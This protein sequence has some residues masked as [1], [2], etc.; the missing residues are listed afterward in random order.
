MY[1]VSTVVL[2]RWA[3]DADAAALAARVYSFAKFPNKFTNHQSR[4]PTKLLE[5]TEK[6]LDLYDIC[7]YSMMFGVCVCVC[8]F[9]VHYVVFFI[10][11]NTFLRFV[12]L[13]RFVHSF[14]AHTRTLTKESEWEP[15]LLFSV[16][17]LYPWIAMNVRLRHFFFRSFSIVEM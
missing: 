7:W 5:L 10:E 6:G 13:C 15:Y 12:R 3:D 1:N 11:C 2:L 4:Q 17:I 14:I 8:K 16:R 9:L